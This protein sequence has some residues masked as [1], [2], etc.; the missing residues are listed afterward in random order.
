MPAAGVGLFGNDATLASARWR[1]AQ[2]A[3][4]QQRLRSAAELGLPLVGAEV[5]PGSSS[6]RNYLRCGFVVAYTRTHYA[7]RVDC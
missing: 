2:R 3:A 6:E 7:R 1:G 4:I 5:A